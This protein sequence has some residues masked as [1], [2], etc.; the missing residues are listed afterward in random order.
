MAAPRDTT[1][2]LNSLKSTQGAAPGRISV[3]ELFRQHAP[4]LAGLPG[5]VSQFNETGFGY[6]WRCEY[7][8][9]AQTR[10]GENPR[11]LRLQLHFS[12]MDLKNRRKPAAVL[13]LVEQDPDG[14]IRER[15]LLPLEDLGDAQEAINAS[16]AYR[17]VSIGM[18]EKA[19]RFIQEL[20]RVRDALGEQVNWVSSSD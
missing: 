13:Y 2:R 14:E 6:E 20:H 5:E 4:V 16:L 8:L 15:H 9:D 7:Q 3:Y 19:D 18:L 11:D 10:A 1:K 17:P 12:L